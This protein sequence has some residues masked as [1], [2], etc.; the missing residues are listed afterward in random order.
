MWQT[1]PG[2]GMNLGVN[3][4]T[5]NA[6]LDYPVESISTKAGPLDINLAYNSLDPDSTG[7][8]RGWVLTVGP[9]MDPENLP[10]SLVG[11]P[12]N[13]ALLVKHRDGSRIAFTNQDPNAASTALHSWKASGAD[14]GTIIENNPGTGGGNATYT[15]DPTSGGRFQFDSK[16]TRTHRPSATR[17]P[18]RPP[19]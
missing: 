5:G 6:Y 12:G 1:D 3:E 17:P 14:G 9:G 8:G 19:R 2:N 10:A 7:E 13:Q 15:Y 16:T 18:R 4:A 11:T